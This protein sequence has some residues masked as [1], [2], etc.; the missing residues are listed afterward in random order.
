VLVA[1]VAVAFGLLFSSAGFTAATALQKSTQP[2]DSEIQREVLHQLRM[3]NYYTV[4][5]DLEYGVDGTRVIL[6]GEVVNPVL[7]SEAVAAVKSVKGVTDVQDNIKVLAVSN[8]D[9]RIR[10]EAY[11]AIYGEPQLS[12]YGFQ[13]TQSIH[14][15]VDSGHITLVGDVDNVGDRNLAGLRAKS[16]TGAFSVTNNLTVHGEH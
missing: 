11:H 16:A 13:S 15:I 3:L 9:D 7:K 12:K 2:A 1:V 14:I 4:F 8:D 10:R 5:D 6:E